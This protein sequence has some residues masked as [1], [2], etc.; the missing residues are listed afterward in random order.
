MSPNPK[1]KEGKEVS[2]VFQEPKGMHDVLPADEAYWSRIESAVHELADGYGFHRIDTPVLEFAEV[3]RK[4]V[5]ESSDVFAK[6]MY[7]LKTR[8]GDL[9]ALRPEYTAPIMRAYLGHSLGRLGQPQKLFAMGPMF[10]HDNPQFGRFRQFT[11]LDFEIIG[12]QNDSIYDAQIIL[13]FLRL[14]ALLRVKNCVLKINSIGCRVCQ[15][16]YR[17]QLVAYYRNHEKKLCEDCVCR[18]KTNPLRL[19]DCKEPGCVELRERAPNILDKLCSTC[20]T[21]FKGVIE[22]L[23]ELKISYVLEN[24]LVRGLEYY[25]RTVFEIFTEGEGKEAGALAG[26][27]R[28]DYLA[29]FLGGHA[30]PGV[31]GAAAVERIIPVMKMQGLVPVLKSRTVVFVAHAGDLAKRKSFRFV[32]ELRRAGI[33]VKEALAK[34]SLKAQLKSADKEGARLALIFGQREIYEGTVIVRDLG[35]G[36][37]ETVPL[38]AIVEEIKKRLR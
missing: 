24:T 2:K 10:R 6:E 18:F 9:L 19:L 23:D 21:H 14:F 27:G 7:S 1:K 17:R 28:Y 12:G 20:S 8:G 30:T 26:G 38:D 25:S 37:Q 11:Q 29:E 4:T 31:G 3:F 33:H 16:I 15:P 34:E 13:L 22:Y 35:S 32:E 5:G 36:L